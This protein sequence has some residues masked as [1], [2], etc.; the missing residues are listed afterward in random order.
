[1]KKIYI[2]ILLFAGLSVHAQIKKVLLE[3]YTGAWCGYCPD[4][5]I[6]LQNLIESNDPNLI[7]IAVHNADLLEVADGI[8]LDLGFG[9]NSY[10][11]ATIDRFKFTGSPIFS[12]RTTWAGKVTDR[13][14]EIAPVSVGFYNLTFDTS[15]RTLDV[16]VTAQFTSGLTTTDPVTINL[17]IVE[18]SIEATVGVARLQQ[19]NY[20]SSIG[21]NPL[22]PWFH[23]HTLRDW[24]SGAW[25][26]G[27]IIPNSPVVGDLYSYQ[28][29]YTLD[30]SWNFRHIDLV[31]TVAL[32]GSTTS[33]R[34]ILNAEKVRLY[35]PVDNTSVLDKAESMSAIFV[36]PN[37][38]NTICNIQ[39]TNNQSENVDLLVYDMQGN[40]VAKPI[41][42][43]YSAV[44][45]T[46]QWDLRNNNG[47]KL[48]TGN[49][50]IR[51]ANTTSSLTKVIQIQ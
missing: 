38:S 46:M 36:Y 41:S 10:P 33:K 8:T 7:G 30:P 3:D 24:L 26:Q 42:S 37:P 14:D 32:N 48:Q 50:I 45:H 12:G 34:E 5:A 43:F 28:Y 11:S 27:G 15:T 9:V 39:F 29:T 16:Y 2:F 17:A 1:M 25:G 35:T 49:Y 40:I 51:L 20:L 13:M 44:T 4:G 18:D 19:T 22:N 31:A 21:G 47:E 23:N 6:I